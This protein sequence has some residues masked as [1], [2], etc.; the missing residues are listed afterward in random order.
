MTLFVDESVDRQIVDWLRRDG[1]SALYVAEMERGVSDEAVIRAADEE[2]AVLLTADK[3][4]GELMFRQ[5]RLSQGCILVR[6]AGLSPEIKAKIVASV[7]REHGD[8]SPQAFT[9]ISPHAL[10]IRRI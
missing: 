6:L 1:H 4:F 7:I 2:K 9:V 10:R 8:E 5:S 3:D